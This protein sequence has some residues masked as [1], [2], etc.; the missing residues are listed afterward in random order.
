VDPDITPLWQAEYAQLGCATGAASD[1]WS[2][3]QEY[4]HGAMLWRSDTKQITILYED[5]H[6]QT[7]ADTW[8]G[9]TVYNDKAPA[10]L[11]TPERGFAWAW[12][13]QAGVQSSL[14]WATSDELGFCAHLQPFEH[15]FAFVSTG[16]PCSNEL[17]RAREPGF[18]P[19]AI[20]VLQNGSWNRY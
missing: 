16:T 3:W 12:H 19:L 14:G 11:V 8:D 20:V 15:G 17:N 18:R 7:V 4:E 6:Q 5:G 2:A 13:N 1:I 9:N 10:G